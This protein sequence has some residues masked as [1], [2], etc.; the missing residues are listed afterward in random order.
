VAYLIDQ[1]ENAL[2]TCLC[3]ML[4]EDGRPVCACHHYHGATRPP[5]D[6]CGTDGNGG[7]GMAWLRR[8]DSEMSPQGESALR[9]WGG[10]IC[11]AS[12]QWRTTIEIGIRRCISAV[13]E[14]TTP[15]PTDAYDADR[16]LLN[17]DKQVLYRVLC[18]DVW[19]DDPGF[20]VV[21]A[22][23]EP[24]GPLGKCSGSILTIELAGDVMA[25]DDV[26]VPVPDAV[27]RPVVYISG[28]AGV[29]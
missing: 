26:V 25:T 23:V 12:Q 9:T 18:C 21:S 7:N 20:D 6:R 15:P 10:G 14:D 8:D 19:S 28:P 3:E 1:L 13:Q 27:A 2:L 4:V 5:G 24:L 17:A 22:R 11:G 16:E 29:A